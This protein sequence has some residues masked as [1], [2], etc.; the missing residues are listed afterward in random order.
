LV[1]PS[2]QMK[3]GEIVEYR[4]E[5]RSDKGTSRLNERADWNEMQGER[6]QRKRELG[7]WPEGLVGR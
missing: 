7:W 3:K 5:K 4:R 1:D 2:G 6:S